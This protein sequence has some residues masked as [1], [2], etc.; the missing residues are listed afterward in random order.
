MLVKS[1][2]LKDAFEA[3]FK[4]DLQYQVLSAGGELLVE[5]YD[6]FE[7][8]GTNA[9]GT[10]VFQAKVLFEGREFSAA[11]AF[12]P[13]ALPIEVLHSIGVNVDKKELLTSVFNAVVQ[14]SF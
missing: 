1:N 14:K 4:R 9:D 5:V 13:H 6:D 11:M 12:Y 3:A 7:Y 10:V 2:F 8:T